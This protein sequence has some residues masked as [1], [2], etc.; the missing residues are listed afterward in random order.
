MAS[1]G[2]LTPQQERF[3]TGIASGLSQAEAYRQAYPRSRKWADESV[4][5]RASRL[6]GNAKVQSRANELKAKAAAE[7]EITVERIQRELAKIAFG[8]PRD[9][10]SWGPGGVK[11]RDSGDLTPEQAVAVAEVTETVTKDGGS[12]KLK[13]HDKVKALELLGR[14]HGAFGD[15]QKLSIEA[16]GPMRVKLVIGERLPGDGD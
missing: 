6:A 8:D 15:G 11:L 13:K 10:M 7:N 4:W 14:I 12:I 9:L 1:A 3:A 5:Q 16:Q 2:G